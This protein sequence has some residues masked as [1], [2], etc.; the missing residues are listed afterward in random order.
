MIEQILNSLGIFLSFVAGFLISPELIGIPRIQ[1][2]ENWT[3][4]KLAGMRRMITE[5]PM[6]EGLTR[7]GIGPGAN[8][9]VII[10]VLIFWAYARSNYDPFGRTAWLTFWTLTALALPGWLWLGWYWFLRP[11]IWRVPPPFPQGLARASIGAT[12]WMAMPFVLPLIVVLAFVVSRYTGRQFEAIHDFAR[13][14]R[15]QFYK[16]P[17]FIVMP[18][19]YYPLLGFSALLGRFLARL[20]GDD[21]LRALLVT[22]GIGFMTLGN[23]LQFIA[24]WHPGEWTLVVRALKMLYG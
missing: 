23:G 2:F 24:T 13:G 12:I 9:L 18:L 1:K 7:M 16:I 17:L 20:D 8:I 15:T 19:F 5:S 4:E 6:L 22:A 21:K 11:V 3:E 10:G 14:M